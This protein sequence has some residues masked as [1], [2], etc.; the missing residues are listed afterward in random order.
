MEPTTFLPQWKWRVT[1]AAKTARDLRKVEHDLVVKARARRGWRK[2]RQKYV[3]TQST[4]TRKT[5]FTKKSVVNLV[6]RAKRKS[7]SLVVV[8]ATARL[9]RNVPVRTAAVAPA[10]ATRTDGGDAAQQETAGPEFHSPR[11][12][13]PLKGPLLVKPAA[14]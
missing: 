12:L 13:A 1:T 14:S 9:K 10:E 6:S 11:R 5:L 8:S 3:T 4:P 2:V 7:K